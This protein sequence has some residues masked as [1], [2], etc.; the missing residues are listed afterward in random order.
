MNKS[1]RQ[2]SLHIEGNCLCRR[3]AVSNRV[4]A[5]QVLLSGVLDFVV[6]RNSFHLGW[7]SGDLGRFE[8]GQPWRLPLCRSWN[9]K[10]TAHLVFEDRRVVGVRFDAPGAGESQAFVEPDGG[11]IV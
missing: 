11:A 6:V 5:H 2:K 10:R 9:V 7:D 1:K 3:K 8:E 4:S